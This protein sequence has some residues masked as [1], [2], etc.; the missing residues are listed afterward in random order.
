MSTTSHTEDG[1]TSQVDP[2]MALP[3]TPAP[4]TPGLESLPRVTNID[5]AWLKSAIDHADLYRPRIGVAKD[6]SEYGENIIRMREALE[7]VSK[8][9]HALWPGA[10]H[11]VLKE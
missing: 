6:L 8:L 9:K 2:A 3:S 10:E 7:K 5:I 1:S 11:T 4:A